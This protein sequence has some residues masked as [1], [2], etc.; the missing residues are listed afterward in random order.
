MYAF[1]AHDLEMHAFWV[2]DLRECVCVCPKAGTQRCM[3]SGHMIS[4]G[5]CMPEGR[6]T[7]MH[8]FWAYDLEMHA[9]WAYDLRWC[10]YARRAGTL[11]CTCAEEVG[12]EGTYLFLLFESHVMKR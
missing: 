12:G 4:S 5:G 10:V 2:Y 11:R 6:D 3:P 7:E 8:A 9:F 1:W